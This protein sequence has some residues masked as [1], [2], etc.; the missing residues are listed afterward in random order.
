MRSRNSQERPTPRSALPAYIV[1][2]LG[3]VVGAAVFFLLAALTHY[4]IYL[5]AVLTGYFCMLGYT[6]LHGPKGWPKLICL[7]LFTVIAITLGFWLFHAF[8]LHTL[9]ITIFDGV[10]FRM[11]IV[12]HPVP[13]SGATLPGVLKNYL[14]TLVFACLGF[15]GKDMV[16]SG[17][18]ESDGS[19]SESEE[20]AD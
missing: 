1:A 15:A 19:S 6:Q 7:S 16:P 18:R 11:F 10:S 3:A 17:K 9:N 4:Y 14:I 5:I 20:D 12:V 8:R 13:A 2:A